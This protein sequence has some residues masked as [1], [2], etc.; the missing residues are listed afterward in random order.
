MGQVNVNPPGGPIVVH[1]EGGFSAG[2]IIGII[3]VILIVL[4]LAFYAGP[5]IFNPGTNTKSLL[6]VLG[7]L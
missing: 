1:D 7:L 6:D 3:L 5:R 4:V 2:M